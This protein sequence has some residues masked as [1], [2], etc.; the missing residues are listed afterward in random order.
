MN[1]MNQS[2]NQSINLSIHLSIYL[3]IYLSICLSIYPS[4]Y[5]P[6]Y[7]SICLSIYMIYLYIGLS[8]LSIYLSICLSIYRSI[9]LSIYLSIYLS[10][11]ICKTISMF[12]GF[13]AIDT[14]CVFS[15]PRASVQ[16][17]NLCGSQAKHGR[18]SRLTFLEDSRRVGE[19]QWISRNFWVIRDAHVWFC[20]NWVMDWLRVEFIVQAMVLTPRRWLSVFQNL[21]AIKSGSGPK[22]VKLGQ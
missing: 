15:S 17:G 2:I 19:F 12:W 10:T 1:Q 13:S 11:S 8:N 22:N 14:V 5:L 6:I 18:P 20:H 7:L 9:D 3:P 16:A 4:I 21:P